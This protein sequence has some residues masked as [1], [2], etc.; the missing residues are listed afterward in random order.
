MDFQRLDFLD[1]IFSFQTWIVRIWSRS[2]E[3][4][5]KW[6][7]IRTTLENWRGII[8]LKFE[9]SALLSPPLNSDS[10][11]YTRKVC[12]SKFK[13]SQFCTFQIPVQHPDSTAFYWIET[14][15]MSAPNARKVLRGYLV[16][17]KVPKP[18]WWCWLNSHTSHIPLF[19]RCSG[20][21]HEH[22]WPHASD[23]RNQ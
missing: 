14:K 10:R 3:S 6:I 7:V 2:T 8:F 23:W 12:L 16:I 5:S 21:E 9:L 22:R 18:G 11:R 13:F 15:Y 19:L 4:S 1:K 20:I 17:K